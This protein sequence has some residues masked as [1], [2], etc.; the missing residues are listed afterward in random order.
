MV[1]CLLDK[2]EYAL[3]P[4][5]AAAPALLLAY[6]QMTGRVRLEHVQRSRVPCAEYQSA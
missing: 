5:T 3:A 4:N 2:L 1:Y 6:L